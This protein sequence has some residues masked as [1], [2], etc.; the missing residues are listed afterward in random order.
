MNEAD[1]E[2]LTLRVPG[3]ADFEDSAA[4][5]GDP[6]VVR[7]I[8]GRAFTREESWARLLRYLGHWQLLGFGF[9]VVRER[10]GGRFVGEV[11]I[12]NFRRD[13]QP[14]LDGGFEI[15][16]ALAPSAQGKGY[17]TEAA[18]ASLRWIEDRHAPLRT[19]CVINPE[20]TASVG[21]ARKCGY[22]EY[23]RT[24][25]KESPV[26]LLERLAQQVS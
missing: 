25:Y 11:G 19:V 14:P 21:V 8:T 10:E 22:A 20:N 26:I 12:G 13:I 5:W 18:L 3:L 6:D 16:W 24:T 4:M 23:A 15:G 2:R 1:T 7:H 9:W 17:A